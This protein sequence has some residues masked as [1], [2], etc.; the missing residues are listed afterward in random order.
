MNFNLVEFVHLNR[1]IFSLVFGF[2]FGFVVGVLGSSSSVEK[3]RLN[4]YAN[5]PWIIRI[6][7]C[8]VGFFSMMAYICI[9]FSIA[10]FSMSLP[11]ILFDFFPFQSSFE[12]YLYK[13]GVI[14]GMGVGFFVRRCLWLYL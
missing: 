11:N 1:D 5:L 12:N 2:I 10:M 4:S 3:R 6:T 9:I 7:K 13:G 8:P 14:F